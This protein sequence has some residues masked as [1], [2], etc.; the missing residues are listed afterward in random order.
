MEGGLFGGVFV[1]FFLGTVVLAVLGTVLW[2]VALVDLLRRPS[3]QWVAAGQNQVVWALVVVLGQ[4]IGAIV[5]WL[6]ARPSLRR[7]QGMPPP[8]PGWPPAPVP[9]R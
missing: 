1:L 4:L 5:Y 6:V 2:V 8:P 7:V 3:W 9:P